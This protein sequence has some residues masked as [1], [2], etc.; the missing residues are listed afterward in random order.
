MDLK[1]GFDLRAYVRNGNHIVNSEW[2]DY[3]FVK[4]GIECQLLIHGANGVYSGKEK[5]EE[6]TQPGNVYFNIL[7]WVKPTTGSDPGKCLTLT[8]LTRE[9][10]NLPLGQAENWTAQ[11]PP[12]NEVKVLLIF[13]SQDERDEF[14]RQIE[15]RGGR[16]NKKKKIKKKKT[17]KIKKNKTKR[18]KKKKTKR[19]NKKLK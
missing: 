18:R 19:R 16:R 2:K 3:H 8:G 9:P 4:D 15:M 12:G 17:K 6:P 5:S 11:H 1:Q 7:T 10:N 13:N 14:Y